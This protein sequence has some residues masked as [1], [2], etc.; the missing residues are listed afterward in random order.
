MQT[1]KISDFEFI[2]LMA[3][4]MALASLSIDALLPGLDFIGKAIGTTDP[5]DN[6]F[7]ITIIILGLGVGQMVSGA[8]SDSIG[9]KPVMYIGCSLFALASVVCVFSNSFEVMIFGRL[10]QGIGLSAPRS[11]SMAIIRDKYSG[12]LMAKIMSYITVIFILAPIIAPTFGKV[13]LD[14]WGWESIF[15]SQLIF[16]VIVTVWF[17]QRQSETLKEEDKKVMNWTLFREGTK[18]F[19]KHRKAVIYTVISGVISAPFLTYISASQQIFS[20][21][22]SLGDIYPYIFSGLALGIGVATFLNGTLVMKYGMKRMATIPMVAILVTAMVY[23]A[24][25]YGTAN[26]DS[27]IFIVFLALI[28]FFTGF[29][30]GNLNALAMEPIGHIAGVGASI[31]GLVSTIVSVSIATL[32]GQY[33]NE[34]ALPI[35][36]GF[37]GCVGVSLLLMQTGDKTTPKEKMAIKTE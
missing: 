10:L 36:I 21:Q 28:L 19:F 3:S 25:Y 22:Y 9:R 15:Y 23:V 14:N 5:K 1:K 24:L 7:L 2:G 31:I 20:Q 17:W 13:L 35:F 16:G 33:I 32:M 29:T 37:V 11:V 26:P 30:F 12:N 4:L 27:T 6:Q 34:T 18:E 8:L